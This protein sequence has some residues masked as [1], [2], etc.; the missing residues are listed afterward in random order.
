MFF[1]FLAC[2]SN[3]GAYS[4]AKSLCQEAVATQTGS[5]P[6][7]TMH[8][9]SLWR[10]IDASSCAHG[11][12]VAGLAYLSAG[13]LD[14]GVAALAQAPAED[15]VARGALG[16]AHELLARRLAAAGAASSGAYTA[17]LRAAALH[18]HVA[19]NG[20]R[21]A[22]KVG[23]SGSSEAHHLPH[24]VL[25]PPAAYVYRSLGGV[26]Q[27]LGEEKNARAVYAA[28]LADTEV[29]WPAPWSR[30]A[31][32]LR[33]SVPPRAWYDLDYSGAPP[34]LVKVLST[35]VGAL[36]RI[37]E[38]FEA[39]WA[40]R[41]TRAWPLEAAGLHGSR[42][43]S[44][45]TLAVGGVPNGDACATAAATCALLAETPLS[46]TR[47]GQAKFSVLRR[48]THILPHA[49]P[50]AA[51]LR[52]HCTLR[53]FDN[54][55]SAAKLRVGEFFRHWREEECFVFDE[56]FEHEVLTDASSVDAPLGF[57][58]DVASA[59]KGSCVSGNSGSENDDDVR[60]VLIV[61]L[62]NPFILSEVD[63]RA[64]AVTA[65][66]WEAHENEF[67]EAMRASASWR[68]AV[69]GL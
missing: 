53:T 34:P 28:G 37:R 51:S 16:A 31:E 6:P 9:A 20:R 55:Y 5:S 39:L 68:P 33:L 3:S 38:D 29:G 61:D 59:E 43:W 17:A 2:A 24:A 8:A 21:A 57:A 49:G 44:T 19:M 63:F 27:W 42:S 46:A 26:L 12:A 25:A 52:M 65:A 23:E 62:A 11:W 45:L 40:A 58:C 67:I 54:G 56:S 14:A 41:R 64:H 7:P 36:P 69:A 47:A 66:A 22:S 10:G 4:I 48:G 13:D 50:R 32:P 1:P 15:W 30:P 18:F 60:A 35:F